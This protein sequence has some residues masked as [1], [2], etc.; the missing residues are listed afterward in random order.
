MRIAV[1]GAGNVGR[2]LGRRLSGLGH[3]VVFGVRD[4]GAEKHAAIT[5]DGSG[6][7]VASMADAAGGADLVVLAV[8]VAALGD[9]VDQAGDLAGSVVADATNV[10]VGPI[11]G[12]HP[13]VAHHVKALVGEVPV[14]KAWNTIGWETMVDPS[15]DDQ[16]AVLPIAGDADGRGPVADLAEAMGFEVLDLGDLDAAPLVEAFARIWI[17]AML[18]GLGRDW[19]FG[20]LRR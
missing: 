13:S 2:A 1:M 12:G 14:V 4:P 9:V 8:P 7:R 3:E 10:L 20:I 16:P 5:D 17:K 6:S 18:S 15:F 19:A 11:P